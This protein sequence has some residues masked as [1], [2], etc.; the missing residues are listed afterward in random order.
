MTSHWLSAEIRG[1]AS[2]SSQ[3]LERKTVGLR[4][5]LWQSF[6]IAPPFPTLYDSNL[7]AFCLF[8]SFL[9]VTGHAQARQRALLELAERLPT[10]HRLI[11][12]QG[13]TAAF[14]NKMKMTSIDHFVQML[15]PVSVGKNVP[16]LRG[17]P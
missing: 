10:V 15:N 2:A 4:E 12:I 16:S 17:S 11:G 8:E 14:E 7:R 1:S 6:H 13:L 9:F 3:P 5:G